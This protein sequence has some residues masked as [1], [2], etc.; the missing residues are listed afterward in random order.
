MNSPTQEQKLTAQLL[1]ADLS[2]PEAPV[3]R[4]APA[5]P[6]SEPAHHVRIPALPAPHS[7]SGGA[8]PTLWRNRLQNSAAGRHLHWEVQRQKARGQ[9]NPLRAVGAR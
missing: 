4:G 3:C 2:S 1:L 8:D 7:E 9:P 6:V 5:G